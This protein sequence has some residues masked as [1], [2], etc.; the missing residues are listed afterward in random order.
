VLTSR[1]CQA[2]QTA[3]LL[4][5]SPVKDEP[6]FDN[7]EFNKKRASEL[8]DSERKLI[9]SWHG[10]GALLI[11]THGGNIK[12]LTGLD[13]EQGAIVVANPFQES[14][15]SPRFSKVVLQTVL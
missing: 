12:A 4:K 14:S 8:L 7:L 6:S 5:L 10:L 11:V 15:V 3:E 13:I 2:R 1:W 9:A